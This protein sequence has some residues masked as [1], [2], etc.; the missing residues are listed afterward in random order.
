M[1]PSVDVLVCIIIIIIMIII[2]M[3]IIIIIIYS[4]KEK[5]RKQSP[6]WT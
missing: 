5:W 4:P 6:L 3:I 2:I 1:D